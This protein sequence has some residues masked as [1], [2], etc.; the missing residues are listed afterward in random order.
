MLEIITQIV[1]TLKGDATLTAIIPATNI[2][3]GPIDVTVEKESELLMPQINIHM[4]SESSR[5][6]PPNTR[7][8]QIQID[9]WSRD[10]QLEVVNAYERIMALLTYF[11]ADQSTAHIFWE[12]LGSAVDQ[13]ESDRRIF[14]RAC[15]F[16][17]WS[18]K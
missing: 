14:H 8:T 11:S 2:M 7:D 13:Y 6:V 18:Q 17:V 16:Q 9:I 5:S 1:N 15:T 4:V 12:R 3:V 10:S